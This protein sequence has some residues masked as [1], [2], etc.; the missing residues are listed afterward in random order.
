MKR[1]FLVPFAAL[2]LM[3]FCAAPSVSANNAKPVPQAKE[4]AA[5]QPVAK[6]DSDGGTKAGAESDR[7]EE[8]IAADILGEVRT[9]LERLRSKDAK[10][11]IKAARRLGEMGQRATPAIPS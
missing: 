4:E 10:E 9:E 8:P 7:P 2:L 1:L 6:A 11:R 3:T 5:A